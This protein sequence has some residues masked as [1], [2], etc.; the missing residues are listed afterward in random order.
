M[1]LKHLALAAAAL[2]VFGSAAIAA[3][4]TN[5]LHLRSGPGGHY[6][7]T[8]SMPAG[9]HVSIRNCTGTWCHVRF[10]GE[11]GY[12]SA[13]YLGQGRYRARRSY[14]S[15]RGYRA[16]G[17]APATTPTTMKARAS[18]SA[19]GRSASASVRAG[20]IATIADGTAITWSAWAGDGPA[21]VRHR[22]PRVASSA[23]AW[24][25][26]RTA[27][28]RQ[29]VA[30]RAVAGRSERRRSTSKRSRCG[31]RRLQAPPNTRAKIASTCLK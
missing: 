11:M 9:A 29:V 26:L 30:P 18:G 15:Y 7:V 24:A 19:S 16:Y 17:Q 2:L 13:S 14:R 10:R 3:V 28:M 4:V 27:S 1:K 12:A 31:P 23:A 5:P 25:R 21:A 8:E 22:G 6:R 20:A